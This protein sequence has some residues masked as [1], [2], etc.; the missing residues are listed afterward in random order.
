MP[1][2]AGLSVLGL[3]AGIAVL[4]GPF[5]FEYILLCVALGSILVTIWI[6]GLSRITGTLALG[7]LIFTAV[8]IVRVGTEVHELIP[9]L[10]LISF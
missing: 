6:P 4:V 3:I 2:R 7:A 5:E 1:R 10:N 9:L 8:V